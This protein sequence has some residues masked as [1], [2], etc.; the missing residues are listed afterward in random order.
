[1]WGRLLGLCRLS[2][3][4]G[5]EWRGWDWA[6]KACRFFLQG[7]LCQQ[8]RFSS[9]SRSLCSLLPLRRGCGRS[10]GGPGDSGGVGTTL[11]GRRSRVSVGL[12]PSTDTSAGGLSPC[13]E[14][15]GCVCT[16]NPAPTAAGD[17]EGRAGSGHS[18]GMEPASSSA[19]LVSK[20]PRT[21]K[22]LQPIPAA[23]RS[24]DA[25]EPIPEAACR[26]PSVC[27]SAALFPEG[28]SPWAE[29]LPCCTGMGQ[30]RLLREGAGLVAHSPSLPLEAGAVRLVGVAVLGPPCGVT[31]PSPLL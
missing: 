5:Q 15:A 28:K 31:P 1:M 2:A 26:F 3:G 16:P 4:E 23:L 20:T 7:A 22:P 25:S 24:T 6:T 29:R 18:L 30:E 17:P 12:R 10:R 8:G 13:P 21:P 27:S 11:G 14:L 19:W 9:S